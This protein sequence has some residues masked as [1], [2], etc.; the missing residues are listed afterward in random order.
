MTTPHPALIV[1]RYAGRR[2]YH[3]ATGTY[4]AFEDLVAKARNGQDIPV[5]DAETGEDVTTSVRPILVEH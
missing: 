1:K 2:F 3:G 4:L 5:Y